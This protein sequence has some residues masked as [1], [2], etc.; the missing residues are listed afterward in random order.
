MIESLGPPYAERRLLEVGKVEVGD[1]GRVQARRDKETHFP[2]VADEDPYVAQL[3][4]AGALDVLTKP[5]GTLTTSPRLG[6]SPENCPGPHER[7]VVLGARI[8][9]RQTFAR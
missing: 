6:V 3:R 9:P 7:E 8:R 5:D 4:T 2:G 1:A